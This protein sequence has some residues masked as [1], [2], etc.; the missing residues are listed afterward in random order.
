MSTTAA[1]Q[2]DPLASLSDDDREAVAR[3]FRQAIA[4]FVGLSGA[5]EAERTALLAELTDVRSALA[6]LL[7]TVDSET[8]LAAVDL[9]RLPSLV[10][11]AG[12]PEAVST[13]DYRSAVAYENLPA[14]VD[15]PLLVESTDVREGW[16]RTEELREEIRDVAD[17]VSGTD[18][19]VDD[20]PDADDSAATDSDTTDDDRRASVEA[21]NDTAE[22]DAG[23]EVAESL[24][25]SERGRQLLVQ[26]SVH[27]AAAE[28]R[29]HVFDARERLAAAAEDHELRTGRVGQPDSRNPS[30][31]ST[32]PRARLP[33]GAT[34]STVPTETRHS[35]APNFE[36]V[37]G[38]RFERLSED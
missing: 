35:D 28:M 15:A 17:A 38:R 16:R 20:G 32:L 13:G 31:F 29:E 3:L 5:S 22:R 12:I 1:Q 37:Y 4:G 6:A 18:G 25:G 7:E 2:A 30:A 33:T 27:A 14:F 24:V 23:L 19:S 36:R 26:K 8:L 34:F 9:E 21:A 10:D 11:W